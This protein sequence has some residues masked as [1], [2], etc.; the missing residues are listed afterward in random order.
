MHI[1]KIFSQKFATYARTDS[2][3]FSAAFLPVIVV[4]MC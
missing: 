4:R 1:D 3:T 2:K